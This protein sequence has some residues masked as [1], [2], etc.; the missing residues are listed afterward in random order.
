M[1]TRRIDPTK[2]RAMRRAAPTPPVYAPEANATGYELRFGTFAF[3][4][5]VHRVGCAC[6]HGERERAALVSTTWDG[7]SREPIVARFTALAWRIT[8]GACTADLT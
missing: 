1:T 4:A 8:R 7:I 6:A 5:S 3:R 2:V